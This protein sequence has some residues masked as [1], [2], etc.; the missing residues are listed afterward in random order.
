VQLKAALEAES[1]VAIVFGAELSGAAMA[2]LVAF[3]SKLPGKTRYM[4]LGDYSNSRGAADMGLLP[5]RFPGYAH[6][7]DAQARESFE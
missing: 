7:D 1:E 3:G 2:T 6:V 5:D 4:A